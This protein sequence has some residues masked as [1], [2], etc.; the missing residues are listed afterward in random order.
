MVEKLLLQFYYT[1]IQLFKGFQKVLATTAV[2]PGWTPSVR[3]C[4][5]LTIGNCP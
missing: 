5:S 4:N 3:H 1:V 2:R